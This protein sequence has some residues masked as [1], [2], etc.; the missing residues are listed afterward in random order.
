MITMVKVSPI[1]DII[2]S[3]YIQEKRVAIY[4][5]PEMNIFFLISVI[6]NYKCNNIYYFIP[7]LFNIITYQYINFYCKN[8]IGLILHALLTAVTV[9]DINTID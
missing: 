6:K 1:N 8:E 7:E 2:L 9:L 4:C 3:G 5:Y